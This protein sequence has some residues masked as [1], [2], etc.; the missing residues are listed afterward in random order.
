MMLV[1]ISIISVSIYIFAHNSNISKK[2]IDSNSLWNKLGVQMY[3]Y[4]YTFPDQVFKKV[5]YYKDSVSRDNCID[6][7]FTIFIF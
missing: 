6:N 4:S 3:H 5:N 1:A 2:H 7:Y